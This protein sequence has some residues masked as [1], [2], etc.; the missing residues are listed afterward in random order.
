M[1]EEKYS[2]VEKVSKIK[3]C[4]TELVSVSSNKQE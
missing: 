4:Y 1:F 3:K 2:K